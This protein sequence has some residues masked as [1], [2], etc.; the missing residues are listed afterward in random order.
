M[1]GLGLVS[2]VSQKLK[3]LV[4]MN[5]LVDAVRNGRNLAVTLA[6]QQSVASDRDE[7]GTVAEGQR[8]F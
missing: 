2:K 8:R 5:V 3:A 4:G 1:V 6:S 7:T